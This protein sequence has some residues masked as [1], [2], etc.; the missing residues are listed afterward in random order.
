[1]IEIEITNLADFEKKMNAFPG[2]VIAAAARVL[3]EEA[4]EV[5][6]R[7]KELV[8]V[9]LGTLRDSG[10]VPPT[11]RIGNTIEVEIVYGGEAKEYAVAVHEHLSHHSPPSWF[12]AEYAGRPVKFSPAGTG[13]K[14]LERPYLEAVPRIPARFIEA[15][16]RIFR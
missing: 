6:T 15:F 12:A 11:K 14:F 8:P 1:M 16:K 2:Q 3:R 10:H 4:E 13:P 9:D 7:S 5:M